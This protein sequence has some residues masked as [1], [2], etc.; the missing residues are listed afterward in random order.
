MA[1]FVPYGKC[2]AIAQHS[3][4]HMEKKDAAFVNWCELQPHFALWYE[5]LAFTKLAAS[6][7]Y[8][9]TPLSCWSLIPFLMLKINDLQQHMQLKIMLYQVKSV[10]DHRLLFLMS[11][12]HVFAKQLYRL[13]FLSLE[14][15]LVLFIVIFFTGGSP[16]CKFE[17]YW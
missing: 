6:A 5:V 9:F 8:H 13:I 14:N 7:G 2:N 4:L 17:C 11:S 12:F 3:L 15:L 10:S 16:W 1:L